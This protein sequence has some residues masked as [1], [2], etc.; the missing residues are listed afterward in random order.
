MYQWFD[1]FSRYGVGNPSNAA[2]RDGLVYAVLNA[3]VQNDPDPNE[4]GRCLNVGRGGS[5][6]WT[7]DTRV[8]LPMP[9]EGKVGVHFRAWF[10]SLPEDDG[11]LRPSVVS[12]APV[13]ISTSNL[14]CNIL[15][16]P[17]GSVLVRKTAGGTVTLA[18]TPGPVISPNSWHHWEAW[19]DSSTGE[20]ELYI[21]GI[22]VLDW[23]GGATG[24]T[25]IIHHSNR[26]GITG[27]SDNWYLK[28]YGIWDGEG[29]Q[30][31]DI[32]GTVIVRRLKPIA[33]VT[34]G[35]WVPSTGSTGYDLLAKDAPDDATYLS[36][37][38]APP[39]PMQFNFEK[40][41]P[42][43]TTVRA[44]MSVARMRKIDGG[45][46]NVQISLSPDGNNFDNGADRPITS[47]F[48]YWYDISEISPATAAA[49][50]PIEV[51]DLIG[52]VDRT[53]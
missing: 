20:G 43:T 14:F 47:A 12:W 17:N 26:S 41:D 53:V 21:N 24:T 44:V 39:A 52:E 18:E 34:L 25:A 29:T 15:L 37:D 23:S 9:R 32:A 33:D 48:S 40:L 7:D 27:S 31:N 10:S 13:G 30:N 8:A 38:D 35:G 3:N 6:N 19:Y 36:A 1:D 2:M 49:W 51:D 22:K 46:A 28:D 42:D 16:R 5:N 4:T 11:A 50:T 45:D